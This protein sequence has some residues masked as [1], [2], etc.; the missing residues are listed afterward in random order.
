MITT[1]G[2]KKWL[3]TQKCKL[4]QHK[5]LIIMIK[6]INNLFFSFYTECI[7]PEIVNPQ[8]GKRLL[9]DDIKDPPHIMKNMSKK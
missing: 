1:F 4:F 6:I 9:I 5:T 3:N 8:Y 7:L 2:Y